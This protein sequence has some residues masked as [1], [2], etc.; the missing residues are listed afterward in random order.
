M[1]AHCSAGSARGAL[2]RAQT[3]VEEGHHGSSQSSQ[4]PRRTVT[5]RRHRC[6]C[7]C[8]R[9][10]WPPGWGRRQ[11]RAPARRP[12]RRLTA[13]SPAAGKVV[14]RIGYVG[15]P[16][17]LN[18]FV[19]Q[20]NPSYLIFA[21][22]YDFLVGVD[23]ATLVPS[24][25]TGLAEDWSVSDDGLTWTF[26]LRDGP[27][28]QDNGQPVTSAD[29][30]SCTTTSSTTTCRRTPSTRP[31]SRGHRRRPQDGAVRHREAQG[32][33]AARAQ[34]HPDPAGAHL[35]GRP[36]QAGRA[37]RTPTSRPSSAAAPSSAWS[38]RRAAT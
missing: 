7:C 2:Q 18:P 31:A 12:R 11:P 13:A 15:E 35:E 8:S 38:T 6:S 26:T 34:L 3:P 24:K 20:V 33:H 29:V 30:S 4:R 19:A 27:T 14:L 28:W 32:R 22:N 17:N 23:P 9:S 37:P 36:A 21:T 25:E 10:A 16:D 5:R 1:G